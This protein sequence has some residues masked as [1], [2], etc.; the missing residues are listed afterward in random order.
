[1]SL[2]ARIET[3]GRRIKELSRRLVDRGFE[4]DR[5][6]EVFPGPEPDAEE[7]IARI[8]REAGT[9]PLALKLFWLRVGSVD[10][11][12]AHP[13]WELLPDH[14]DFEPDLYPDP[15]VIYP[16]SMAMEELEEFLADREE[17]LRCDYP[18]VVPIAPD[19]KH[20]ADVSGGMFYNISVPAVADDP[21]LNDQWHQTTLTNY[22]ELAVKW[23]GFPGLERCPRHNWPIAE[24]VRD[25]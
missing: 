1:M 2:E 20:K 14:A 3:A 6:E 8:E 17:R 13:D 23:A 11:C 21:P 12:G 18:Y 15:L 19:A 9:L 22:L 5:P 24:L 4:F 16:P 25:L 7:S 10:F